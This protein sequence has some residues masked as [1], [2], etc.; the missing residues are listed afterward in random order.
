MVYCGNTARVTIS[1]H[2]LARIFLRNK[3]QARIINDS[4]KHPARVLQ[5]MQSGFHARYIRFLTEF[6]N[7][8][9]VIFYSLQ[10]L[11]SFKLPCKI[12]CAF[13]CEQRT[14]NNKSNTFKLTFKTTC[15][16]AFKI[17]LQTDFKATNTHT[18]HTKRTAFTFKVLFF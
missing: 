14:T 10:L 3:L 16:P 11:T 9:Q 17:V 8:Y 13:I 2:N 5:T 4:F 12:Y 1:V 7:V 18:K 15:K 6:M